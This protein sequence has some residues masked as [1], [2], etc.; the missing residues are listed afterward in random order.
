MPMGVSLMVEFVTELPSVLTPIAGLVVVGHH[1]V[2]DD[3]VSSHV[4]G[5]SEDGD[6]VPHQGVPHFVVADGSVGGIVV[7][8]P[9]LCGADVVGVCIH[10]ARGLAK[11]DAAGTSGAGRSIGALAVD[12][13]RDVIAADGAGGAVSLHEDAESGLAAF[14]ARTQ[15]EV[16]HSR[17]CD[18]TGGIAVVNDNEIGRTAGNAPGAAIDS[19]VGNGDACGSV[20]RTAAAIGWLLDRLEALATTGPGVITAPV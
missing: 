5:F 19:N 9:G 13:I 8:N 1:I 3:V 17:F 12:H 4:G 6:A 15:L 16:P 10:R 14:R 11:Q 2:V 20:T 7:V 18:G